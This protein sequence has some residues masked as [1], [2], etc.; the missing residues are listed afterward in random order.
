MNKDLQPFGDHSLLY[1]REFA[2]CSGSLYVLKKASLYVTSLHWAHT[3]KLELQVE[4]QNVGRKPILKALF[5][6][7]EKM[8]I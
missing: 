5:K 4:S 6:K 8:E 2:F 3:N 7:R 1:S